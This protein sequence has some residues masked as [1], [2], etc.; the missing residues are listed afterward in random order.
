MVYYERVYAGKLDAGYQI[1]ESKL[2]EMGLLS[3][4]FFFYFVSK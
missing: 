2:E 4:C 1:T 3:F